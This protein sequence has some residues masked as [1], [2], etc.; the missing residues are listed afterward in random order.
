MIDDAEDT[1]DGGQQC[2]GNEQ[3]VVVAV[4]VRGG[5][6]LARATDYIWTLR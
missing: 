1:D 5:V 6:V 3:L 4:A 2:G